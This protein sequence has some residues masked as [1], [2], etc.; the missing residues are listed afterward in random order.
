MV[1]LT[2]FSSGSGGCLS[3]CSDQLMKELHIGAHKRID[4]RLAMDY[5]KFKGREHESCLL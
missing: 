3:P 5:F 1:A 4:G 2:G